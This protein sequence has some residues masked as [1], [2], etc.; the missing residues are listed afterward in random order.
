MTTS[1]ASISAQPGVVLTVRVSLQV[2]NGAGGHVVTIYTSTNF[3]STWT[4]LGTTLNAGAFTTSVQVT[5]AAVQL[6]AAGAA[7]TSAMLSGK[8]YRA[9]V[10]SDVTLSTNVLTVDADAI[11]SGAA[12]TFTATTGQTVTINRATSGRKSVAMPSKAKG[13]RPCMLLGTD[14]YLECQ[15]AA[16]HGLLNFGSADSFTMFA[17]MRPWTTMTDKMIL[18]KAPSIAATMTGYIF[19]CSGTA[20][21]SNRFGDGVN[22]QIPIEPVITYGTRQMVGLTRNTFAKTRSA[23]INGASS[24]LGTDTTTMSLASRDPLFIGRAAATSYADMEFTAAA[25]FRRALTAREITVLNNAAPW[26]V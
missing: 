15:D 10:Y 12:T 24:G 23:I 3:G 20:L 18:S 1:N 5:T 13:G 26:G 11:T 19:Y 22:R 9:S 7:G 8:V 6:G 21:L 16:Q 2:N 17:V 14:D 25:I 4:Q